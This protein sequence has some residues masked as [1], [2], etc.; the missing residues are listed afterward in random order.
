MIVHQIIPLFNA[1]ERWV[2]VNIQNNAR[3][4]NMTQ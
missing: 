4:K 2:K 3:G 1:G